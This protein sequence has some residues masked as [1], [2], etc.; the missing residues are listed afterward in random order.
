M[1]CFDAIKKLCDQAKLS[2][3]N[4]N[5]KVKWNACYAIGN[6]MK[7]TVIYDL[8]SNQY[9]WQVKTIYDNSLVDAKDGANLYEKC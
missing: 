6:F 8:Q 7:N 5:M 1:V 2:G 3:T 4:W 9:C